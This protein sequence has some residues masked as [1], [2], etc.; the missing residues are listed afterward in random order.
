MDDCHILVTA[1]PLQ[2][3][4]IRR[5]FDR[6][7]GGRRKAQPFPTLRLQFGDQPASLA[8]YQGAD[9]NFCEPR[10]DV[11]CRSLGSPS[12][13]RRNYLKDGPTTQGIATG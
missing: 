4:D 6:I 3:K 1:K 13:E 2:S 11:D 5:H 12:V 10:S 7:L 9:T 8:S